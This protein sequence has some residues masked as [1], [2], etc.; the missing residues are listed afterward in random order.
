MNKGALL[1]MLVM[2]KNWENAFDIRL[3]N[4]ISSIKIAVCQD[5]WNGWI[6]KDG[7]IGWLVHVSE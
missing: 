1:S 2:D 4:L 6:N 5:S 3:F 7:K